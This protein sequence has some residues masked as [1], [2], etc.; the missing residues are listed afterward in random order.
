MMIIGI[1]IIIFVIYYSSGKKLP[2]VDKAEDVLKERFVNG[3][4][5]EATYL[6]MKKTLKE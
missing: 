2:G 1:A 5:D 4:I 3:E 6:R